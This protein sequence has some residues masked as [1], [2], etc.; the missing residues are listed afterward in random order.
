MKT[1]LDQQPFRP[2]D[3]IR[4]LKNDELLRKEFETNVGVGVDFTLETHTLAAMRLYE[5]YFS[6][7]SLPGGV[8]RG[9]FR[10]MLAVHDIGKPRA[11][12]EGDKRRQHHHTRILIE[13]L[14]HRLPFHVKEVKIL[15][16]LVDGDPIGSYMKGIGTLEE[17]KDK[18]LLM[19]KT[20]QMP[21]AVFFDLL[22]VYYQA[23]VAAYTS[24]GGVMNTLD[25]LYEWNEAHDEIKFDTERRRLKFAA[26]I[27][28]LYEK[29]RHQIQL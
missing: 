24:K 20:A 4:F 29:L 22:T 2:E 16:A 23:D 27:E 26:S 25:S 28:T 21:P 15:A 12:A 6:K 7:V 17:A 19:A 5:R 14:R 8:D 13:H 3:L 10:V 11:I 1:V 18:I 9:L